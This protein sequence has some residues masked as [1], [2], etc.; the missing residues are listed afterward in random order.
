MRLFPP[1]EP[2]TH[3]TVL[4]RFL[5]IFYPLVN[6]PSGQEQTKKNCLSNFADMEKKNRSLDMDD[7]C[8]M[9]LQM[10]GATSS[11]S[12]ILHS[13][14][15]VYVANRRNI[16]MEAGGF[17]FVVSNKAVRSVCVLWSFSAS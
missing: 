8:L 10:K 1:E 16:S 17:R 5:V 2:L 4:W 7:F 15:S 3:V 6:T 13:G 14:I 11:S 12:S 9:V